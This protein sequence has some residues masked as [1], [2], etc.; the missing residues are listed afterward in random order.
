MRNVSRDPFG[1]SITASVSDKTTTLAPFSAQVTGGIVSYE[2]GVALLAGMVLFYETLC[3]MRAVAWTDAAQGLLM[4]LGLAALLAWLVG[5][6]GGLG[7][8]TRGV[9]EVRPEAARIPDAR[10]CA[11]WAST[12]AL[13]GLAS[14]VYPQAIQRIYAAKSGRALRQSFALMTF[15]PLATTLVVTLIGLAAISR[16]HGLDTVEADRVMPLLLG[17]WAAAGT[18]STLAECEALVD[19]V[20]D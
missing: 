17:Q 2:V 14:V 19:V 8:V 6:A 11:N 1:F 9:L 13:L 18:L 5:D 3:G 12:I 15:M 4:M 20:R 10:E 16:F 7:A